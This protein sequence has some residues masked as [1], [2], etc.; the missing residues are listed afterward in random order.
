MQL[1]PNEDYKKILETMPTCCVDLMLVHD[2]KFLLLYRKNHPEKDKWCFP[3]GRIHKNEKILDA[4][5]RKAKE[6]LGLDVKIIKPIGFYE[7]QFDKG[8]FPD[9]KTGVHTINLTYLV[10]PL[11]NDFK[12]R[13]D[14]SSE[15]FKWFENF[16]EL[17]PYVQKIIKDSG[18]FN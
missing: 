14:K 12:I 10:K 17:I 3:G 13:I 18:Y 16:N 2:N 6:E 15:N 8:I 1:I 5:K 7:T 9:L 4:V 11:N